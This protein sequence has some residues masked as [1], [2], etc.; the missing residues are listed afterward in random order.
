MPKCQHCGNATTVFVRRQVNTDKFF[1]RRCRKTTVVPIGR[2]PIPERIAGSYAWMRADCDE[3][4]LNGK[5]GFMCF[6]HQ[7]KAAKFLDALNHGGKYQLMDCATRYRGVKFVLTD[8]DILGRRNKLESI[9]QKGVGRFFIY[10]HAARPDLVNDVYP[11]WVWTTAHF[12]VTETHAEVMRKFG[13]SRPLVP[14]GWSLCPQKTFRARLQPYRV[15]FAPIH[16][17]CSEIDQKVN[18]EVFK[19]LEKLAKA[20]DIHLTI[21]FIRSLPESGLERVEHPNIEYTPGA[22]NQGYDQIDN[23]DVVIAHQTFMYLSVARGVPTIAIATDMPTHIQMRRHAVEWAK[24]W[25]SY[26]HLMRFPYDI[27]DCPDRNATL[28]ML[29]AVIRENELVADWRRRLIGSPFR[30]DRFIRK[31]EEFL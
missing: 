16:P 3:K 2:E 5:T 27:L 23:A 22:M 9:R 6:N 17:R 13:Y 15:L 21:R 29:N 19:R 18:R 24:N 26:I 8:T 7:N 25:R 11:E 10:P 28:N 1:C 20:G 12:V 31:L 30:K 14:V 4:P